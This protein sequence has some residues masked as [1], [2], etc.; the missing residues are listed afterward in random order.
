MGGLAA[1]AAAEMTA[2]DWRFLLLL[3]FVNTYSVALLF[4]SKPVMN[5]IIRNFTTT[6][7]SSL[8]PWLNRIFSI[9]FHERILGHYCAHEFM[10]TDRAANFQ[11]QVHI[12]WYV[13]F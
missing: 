4:Y 10:R 11:S 12:C 8:L 3:L 6:K 9:Y 13:A 5:L 1:A 7:E 2:V